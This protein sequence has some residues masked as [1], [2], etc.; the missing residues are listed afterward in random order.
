VILL[1]YRNFN[2]VLDGVLFGASCAA[3]LLAAEALANS[4][5]LLH[6]GFRAPGNQ[7]LWIAR[8]LTLGVTMPV[9]AAGVGGA[10]CGAFWLRFRAP[11]RDRDAVGPLG[12]PLLAVPVA[13]GVLVGAALAELY[14]KQWW[15][16]AVTALAAA[17]GL[18]WLRRLIHLGLREEAAEREIGSLIECPSCHGPTPAHTFCGHCGGALHALPK[19]RAAHADEAP[20]QARIGGGVKIAVFSAL[21]GAAIGLAA[22]AI[23]LSR[24]GSTTPACRPGV[25][26]AAPPSSPVAAPHLVAGV[27]HSGTAWT[28]GRGVGLRY[29]SEWHLVREAANGLVL[30]VQAKSGLYVVVLVLVEPSTTTPADALQSQV[31]DQPDGFLGVQRDPLAPARV[32]PWCRRDVLGHGRPGAEPGREGRDRLRGGAAEHGHRRRRGDHQ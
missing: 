25:P 29:G 8:L 17:L 28:S 26:C 6:L 19:A 10:T 23:A 16:L 5:D 30:Q 18:L 15:T 22:I 11:E 3:T 1:P 12:S 7:G 20:R 24:P 13:A 21:A 4:A 9:L 2:D 14:L 27:F 32:R 31:D